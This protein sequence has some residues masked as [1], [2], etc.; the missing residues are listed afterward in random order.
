VQVNAGI[1]RTL[2]VMLGML[3]VIPG[4]LLAVTNTMDQIRG[5]TG[6]GA[7]T[8]NRQLAP[9]TMLSQSENTTTQTAGITQQTG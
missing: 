6:S 1:R 9:D 2:F 5:L 8:G 7:E 4:V 3:F